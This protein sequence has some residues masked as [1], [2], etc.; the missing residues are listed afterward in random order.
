M[1]EGMALK[2]PYPWQ[3][4]QWAQVTRSL[5]QGRLPHALL[6]MGP[7]GVGKRTFANQLSQLL[8]CEQGSGC[9]ECPACL[10]FENHAHPD[11]RVLQPEEDKRDIS[12][13]SVRKSLNYIQ[14]SSQVNLGWKILKVDPAD[15]MTIGAANAF[16]KTLE[17]PPERRLIILIAEKLNRVPATIRSRCRILRFS[18][19]PEQVTTGWLKTQ[20]I[21]ADASELMQ[22]DYAPLLIALESSL[23]KEPGGK[24][25]ENSDTGQ[26][27][28]RAMKSTQHITNTAERWSDEETSWR[29]CRWL[30]IQCLSALRSHVTGQ[31]A[32]ECVF[33]SLEG[34]GATLPIIANI[35]NN[36][37][38]LLN[39]NHNRRLIWET[40]LL[41]CHRIQS[42]A[43]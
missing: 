1:P 15:Q 38:R 39:S 8:L 27:F 10:K 29:V 24:E 41:D 31:P 12:I 30:Q 43:A 5:V 6:L 34:R 14:L 32:A 37:P 28:L 36:L 2:P 13:A 16:L 17:E 9:G 20:G 3:A 26:E 35:I 11:F 19:V 22:H 21:H 18:S 42:E 7:A 40:F 23:N 25:E 33:D 4:A